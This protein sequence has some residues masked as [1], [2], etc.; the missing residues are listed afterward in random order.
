MMKVLIVCVFLLSFSVFSQSKKALDSVLKLDVSALQTNSE[1]TIQLL[2]K[3]LTTSEVKSNAAL[4]AK[5][6]SLLSMTYYYQGDYASNIKYGLKAIDLYSKL[7]DFKQLSN[8]YAELGFRLKR[9]DLKQAELYMQKGISIAKD[10]DLIRSLSS[11]YNNYGNVKLMKNQPDSALFFYKESL[12]INFQFK[13]SIGV[14]YCYNNIGDLYIKQ[15]KYQLAEEQFNRAL[16]FALALKDQ[17]TL[18]D[19][20]AYFGDLY[21]EQNKFFEASEYYQRSLNI[22]TIHKISN[23]KSH[24]FKMLTKAYEGMNDLK[25]ALEYSKKSQFFDDSILNIETQSKMLEYQT[26]FE[27]VQKEKQLLN[28][29]IIAKQRQFTIFILVAVMLIAVILFLVIFN[30][31]RRR[32]LKQKQDFELKE[33]LN[34]VQTVQKLHNQRVEISKDLHDNIGSQLTFIISSMEMFKFKSP[35]LDEQTKEKIQDIENFARETIAEFRD[36]VWAMNRTEISADDM[37]N[38]ISNLLSKAK[39]A[40]ENI[41]FDFEIDES[42]QDL[43]FNNLVG[44]N[45][46]RIVQEAVNNAIKYAHASNIQVCFRMEEMKCKISIKDNGVGFDHSQI[47][48]G[49]GLIN[50]QKRAS[51]V[52]ATISIHSEIGQGT[53]IDLT[54]ALK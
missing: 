14:P 33:A 7:K 40:A 18:S 8:L 34:Q 24:N 45:V 13:D 16:H 23:L 37:R 12:K 21:L 31:L 17:Y 39:I 32:N 5:V 30:L 43:K 2:Q 41:A 4:Q 47:Q 20:Y 19:T 25:L 28:Q 35:N 6:N 44:M 10:H 51:D 46:F 15:K 3:S 54:I 38:R 52:D 48:P 50:M 27:T 36:T 53:T 9:W 26:R 42:T 49:N 1:A 22:A 29:K 11:I